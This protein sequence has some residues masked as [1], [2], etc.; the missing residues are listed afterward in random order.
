MTFQPPARKKIA[1]DNNKLNLVTKCPTASD[2][3]SKLVWGFYNNSPRITVY[4][5][6]PSEQ[7]VE[8]SNYGR[9][10]ANLDIP[11]LYVLFTKLEEAITAENGFKDKVENKNFTFYGGKRSDA[12]VVQSEVWFGKDKEG[13]IWISVTAKE[14]PVIKFPICPSDY[15]NFYHGDGTPYSKAEASQACAKGYLGFLKMLYANLA[16]TEFVDLL[17]ER[18][19]KN[20]Q[21]GGQYSNQNQNQQRRSNP[22]ADDDIPF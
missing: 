11:T 5:G 8:R 4:T 12:P 3:D 13:L 18:D 1:L 10:V 2:K 22:I 6:D 14:R 16:T 20:N 9:I 15:H 21:S 7:G 17:A 19:K